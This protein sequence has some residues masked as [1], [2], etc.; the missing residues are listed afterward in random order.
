V[1][2]ISSVYAT[3]ALA[4]TGA[5]AVLESGGQVVAGSNPVSP[6][7]VSPTAVSPTDVSPTEK[8]A[9]TS[10]FANR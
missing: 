4:R 2:E 9:L 8:I 10:G 3:A 1:L 7:P 5:D 6:M